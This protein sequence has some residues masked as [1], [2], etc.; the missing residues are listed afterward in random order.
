MINILANSY[1]IDEDWC[2][3]QFSK[4]IKSHHKILVIPFSFRDKDI[5][6]IETWIECYN[7]E[8][9]KYY[10]GVVDSFKRYKIDCKNIK[11]LNYFEDTI[12]SAKEKIEESDILYFTGGLPDKTM[13]RLEEFDL[14][15]HV[16]NHK[17][18]M[19]GFSAG[20]LIQLKDYHLT[21]D[22]DYDSFRYQKGLNMIHDFD[23]EVHFT[24]SEKQV[25][26]I[27]KVIKEKNV[28]VYAI[29]EEGALIIEN[30]E[31]IQVGK[32]HLFNKKN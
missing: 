25:E 10:H 9:G 4:I 14:L 3:N 13:D 17:G 22:K 6:S 16:E 5:Y 8:S 31:I 24:D 18:I 2:F 7:N 23:L 21:S 15:K 28:P 26:S 11:W 29:E 27:D 1:T 19:I 12:E 32:V 20:A 30:D